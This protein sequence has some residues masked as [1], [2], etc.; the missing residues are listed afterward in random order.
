[1]KAIRA[2]LVTLVATAAATLAQA[3]VAYTFDADTQG[4]TLV[5]D[6]AL[7]QIEDV[8]G[9]HEQKR[10]PMRDQ[11]GEGQ[12]PRRDH[13]GVGAWRPQRPTTGPA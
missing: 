4:F 7:A 3:D 12:L 1:M 11:P 8:D 13:A 9:A 6:G 5:G 2:G 10:R